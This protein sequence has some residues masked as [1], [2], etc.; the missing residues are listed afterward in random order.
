M[1]PLEPDETA[2][3]IIADKYTSRKVEVTKAKTVFSDEGVLSWVEKGE[4]E[5]PLETWRETWEDWN[6]VV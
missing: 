4:H 5:Y 3:K 1:Y 2:L 6:D